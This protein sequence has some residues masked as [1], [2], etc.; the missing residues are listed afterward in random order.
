MRR[1]AL[2]LFAGLSSCAMYGT[3]GAERNAPD[4]KGGR[5]DSQGGGF[6]T[7]GQSTARSPNVRIR[8]YFPETLYWNPQLVTDEKGRAEIA[9]PMADS[10]TTWRLTAFANT[11]AGALGSTTK[12]LRVFRDFFVDIDFPVALTQNDVVQVPVAVYNYLKGPQK[13]LLE[14]EKEDWFEL[15]DETLKTVELASGEVKAAHF[16][17]RAKKLGTQRLT[18]FAKSGEADDAIRRTVE[19]VPDGK[20]F[21]VVL[22]DRLS[23]RIDKTF[24]IPKEAIEGSLKVYGKCYPGVF[25]Q[26]IEGVEGMLG[27]PHG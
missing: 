7:T 4:S 20:M 5:F 8:E 21:E 19:I 23:R 11:R 10:I 1:A 6:G 25:A 15:L 16:K 26:V 2:L 9:F 27:M 14:V 3:G 12:G 18:V 24:E 22:N 13:V 17:L